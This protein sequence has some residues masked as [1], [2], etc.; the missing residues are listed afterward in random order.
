MDFAVW[1][2]PAA[3][4]VG[5]D[6]S[7]RHVRPSSSP[8]LKRNTKS[9]QSWG[10]KNAASNRRQPLCMLIHNS[11]R[12]LNISS[13]RKK[14]WKQAAMRECKCF[15]TRPLPPS[16]TFRVVFLTQNCA[17]RTHLNLLKFHMKSFFLPN[18]ASL[19]NLLLTQMR[20]SQMRDFDSRW[21]ELCVCHCFYPRSA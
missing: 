12:F 4:T 18:R 21:A 2:V 14:R 8:I 20:L 19:I 7:R 5:A 3:S 9:V 6:P 11:S 10:S 15:L 16:T 1:I 17:A 13:W